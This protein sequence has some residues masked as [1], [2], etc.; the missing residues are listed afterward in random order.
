MLNRFYES[1]QSLFLFS[2]L[3]LMVSFA[4]SAVAVF[5]TISRDVHYLA[6]LPPSFM[7][8]VSALFGF[9]VL[10]DEEGRTALDWGIVA[11]PETFLVDGSGIVRWKY[12]GAITQDVL[13]Q[14]LIP[15]L[16]KVEAEAGGKH[17]PDMGAAR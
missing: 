4:L 12:S 10:A 2:T 9:L 3:L 7:F 16:E 6:F 1:R 11:A 5:G 17:A 14:Q 15:A 8:F 13:D